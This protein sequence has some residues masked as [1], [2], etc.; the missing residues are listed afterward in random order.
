MV[1]SNVMC[2]GATLD[3]P[4]DYKQSQHT[5][6]EIADYEAMY[7]AIPQE[8]LDQSQLNKRGGFTVSQGCYDAGWTNPGAV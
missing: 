2:F 6:Q 7:A 8:V 1:Y 3:T 5:A 4:E